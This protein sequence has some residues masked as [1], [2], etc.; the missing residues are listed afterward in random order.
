MRRAWSVVDLGFGDAGKGATVDALVREHDCGLV[1]RFNG[2][3]QAGHNVIAPDGRHHTFSQFGAG[4]FVTGCRTLLTEDVLVHP[5]GMLFEN[6]HLI[7]LGVRDAFER[8]EVHRNARLITP[9]QQAANHARERARGLAAH[10]T[11]GVGVG[12]CVRDS[13][14]HPGDTLRAGDL[15]DVPRVRALLGQQRERKRAE[16]ATVGGDLSLFDDPA[17][18]ERVLEA[19]S[20]WSAHVRLVDE[21]E[22]TGRL[23][24]T[25][26]V[27]FEGAQGVLLDEWWGLHPHTTWSD[28]TGRKVYELWDESLMR[29]GVTRSYQCRH[30]AGPFPTEQPMPGV[31]EPHNTED[32]WQGRFRVGALDGML[33]RYALDVMGQVDAVVVRHLDQVARGPVAVA[34]DGLESRFGGEH[35]RLGDREDLTYRAALGRAL[36]SVEPVLENVDVADWVEEWTGRPVVRAR[37]P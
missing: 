35:L 36:A 23:K 5:L 17:L 32:G 18:I 30:G 25:L 12:E 34:Y 29:L 27:V 9:F 15:E 26:R 1:V 8:T 14:E 2:G 21:R 6:D 13:L 16:V 4:T 11:C 31:A 10:G 24:S 22:A 37:R 20:E 19:W 28:C 7:E 3:A 33:L